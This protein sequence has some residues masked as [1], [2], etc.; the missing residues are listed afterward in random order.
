[1]ECQI[2]FESTSERLPLGEVRTNNG[3]VL[4]ATDCEH[5]ICCACMARHVEVQVQEQ[6]VFCLRCPAVGCKSELFEKDLRMLVTSKHIDEAVVDR[7]VEFRTRDFKARAQSFADTAQAEKEDYAMIRH[8]WQTTRL[9]PKCNV[10][11]EK[12]SGCNSFHC[13]C[14][15]R[16]DF[17]KAPRAVGQGIKNFKSIIT[18]AE[19]LQLRFKDAEQVGDWK[20]FFKAGRI[21]NCLDV[22][23]DVAVGI[24]K[25][26][27]QGDAEAREVIRKSR[28]AS[29]SSGED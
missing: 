15:H 25:R 9:C 22:S 17:A 6:R 19:L 12:A 4:R 27:Q 2:C 29:A 11:M 18:M 20:L 10:A 16:F 13:I 1:M 26:A 28:Q 24:C 3:D 23:R 8:L 21:Q 7:F 14:G 5:E